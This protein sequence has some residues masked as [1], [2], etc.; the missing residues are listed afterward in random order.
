MYEPWWYV[1]SVRDRQCLICLQ[2]WDRGFPAI[3]QKCFFGID[4][5]VGLLQ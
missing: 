3:A 5:S 4:V 1:I 2:Q